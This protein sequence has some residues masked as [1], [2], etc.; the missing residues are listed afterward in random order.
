MPGAKFMRV[1]GGVYA[2]IEKAMIELQPATVV[3]GTLKAAWVHR[4][5]KVSK[6]IFDFRFRSVDGHWKSVGHQKGRDRAA[7]LDGLA[8]RNGGDLPPGRYMSRPRGRQRDWDLF[9]LD[10]TGAVSRVR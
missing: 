2:D 4:S 1:F 10:D 3:Q 5:A 7:A 6:V 8:R 9:D